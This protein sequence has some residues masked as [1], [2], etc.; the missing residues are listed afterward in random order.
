ML[1]AVVELCTALL[2]FCTRLDG[3]MTVHCAAARWVKQA[4]T[5]HMSHIHRFIFF[6]CFMGF[7]F[8]GFYSSAR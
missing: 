5:R 1:D 7:T 8:A 6:R 4:R 2:M 3:S